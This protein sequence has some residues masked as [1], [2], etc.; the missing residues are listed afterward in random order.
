MVDR[1]DGVEVNVRV[2]APLLLVVLDA[3]P[4]SLRAQRRVP[5]RLAEGRVFVS[6]VIADDVTRV[7]APGLDVA[8]V[9]D[10]DL[11]LHLWVPTRIHTRRTHH[12]YAST[13]AAS[14]ASSVV[15]PDKGELILR[16]LGVEGLW[17]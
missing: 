7:P 12:P 8:D 2:A 1:L 17:V 3:R 13:L 4:G 15:R 10:E 6:F 11:T 9:R 16:L 5:D 14:R